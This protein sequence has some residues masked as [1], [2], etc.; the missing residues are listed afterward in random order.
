MPAGESLCMGCCC[1]CGRSS[2]CQTVARLLLWQEFDKEWDKE[3]GMW[4]L[5][6]K[7]AMKS[8]DGEYGAL[9]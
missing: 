9:L 3:S 1:C 8:D 6:F 5:F 2:T 4:K 7:Y